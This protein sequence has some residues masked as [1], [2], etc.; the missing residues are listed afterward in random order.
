MTENGTAN[1]IIK[2]W[3]KVA[4]YKKK[5]H[6]RMEKKMNKKLLALGSDVNKELDRNIK[7]KKLIWSCPL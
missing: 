1:D 2:S 3:L 4:S 5:Q 7:Y 6:K